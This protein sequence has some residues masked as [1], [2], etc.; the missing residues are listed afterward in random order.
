VSRVDEHFA[1]K[2]V[3]VLREAAEAISLEMNRT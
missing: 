3:P 2:A 1:D